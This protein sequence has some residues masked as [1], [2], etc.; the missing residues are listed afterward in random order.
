MSTCIINYQQTYSG[1]EDEGQPDCLVLHP[2]DFHKSS[3]SFFAMNKV[4]L[5]LNAKKNPYSKRCREC[6][7][8]YSSF[9]SLLERNEPQRC[10]EDARHNTL[11]FPYSTGCEA[12]SN[13]NRKGMLLASLI[14]TLICIACVLLFTC[15]VCVQGWKWW[16]SA[17]RPRS[18]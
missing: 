7:Q 17:G 8:A 15:S 16:R 9:C 11:H 12:A 10:L 18:F 4:I 3:C 14:S 2:P 1:A 6:F 13:I 5:E